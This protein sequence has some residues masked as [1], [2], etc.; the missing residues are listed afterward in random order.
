MSAVIEAIVKSRIVAI[1]RLPRYDRALEVAHA[2]LEGG[3][4]VIEFTLTGRATLRAFTE[5]T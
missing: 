5:I 1:V 2:L 4:E 3:I